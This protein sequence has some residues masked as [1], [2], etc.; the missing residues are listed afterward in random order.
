MDRQQRPSGASAP[1][2]TPTVPDM[3]WVRGT[4]AL[5]FPAGGP[6]PILAKSE[7]DLIVPELGVPIRFLK[8]PAGEVTALRITIVEGDIDAP[9]V[10]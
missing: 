2:E 8:T 7:D 9:R 1:Q 3:A 10:K 5:A 6:H 4:L